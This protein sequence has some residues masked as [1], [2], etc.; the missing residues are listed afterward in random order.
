MTLISHALPAIRRVCTAK[1]AAKARDLCGRNT[2]NTGGP[3]CQDR[4]AYSR[5]R[6]SIMMVTGPS[7]TSSTCISAP[8]IPLHTSMP[9]SSESMR[10]KAS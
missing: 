6:E 4:Y 5:K 3:R 2:E 9:L 1:A 7:F 10:Q 8:K